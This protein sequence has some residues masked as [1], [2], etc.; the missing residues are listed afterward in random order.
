MGRRSTHTQSCKR[1]KAN[2]APPEYGRNI[3]CQEEFGERM[4]EQQ[5]QRVVYIV[6][7]I[8]V[9]RSR[10]QDPGWREAAKQK[11]SKRGTNI[12]TSRPGLHGLHGLH[13]AAGGAKRCQSGGGGELL[14]RIFFTLPFFYHHRTYR[15]R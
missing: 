4:G 12:T 10:E 13:L 3:P 14:A 8:E 6:G 2:S 15:L 11:K 1:L 5:R 9:R 7:T